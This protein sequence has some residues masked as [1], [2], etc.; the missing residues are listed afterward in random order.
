MITF[1][2]LYIDWL[3]GITLLET[4]ITVESALRNKIAKLQL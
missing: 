2:A 3:K 4:S 1:S